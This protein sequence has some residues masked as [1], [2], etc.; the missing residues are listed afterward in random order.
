MGIPSFDGHV[1]TRQIQ[2]FA[3]LSGSRRAFFGQCIICVRIPT[4]V[5]QLQTILP[6]GN[7]PLVKPPHKNFP[8]DPTKLTGLHRPVARLNLKKGG[9]ASWRGD[10]RD[11]VGGEILHQ[12]R[13]TLWT[14]TMKHWDPK[15]WIR[16]GSLPS[17]NRCRIS[18]PSR[19]LLSTVLQ[20]LW[21]QTGYMRLI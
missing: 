18:Q 16:R 15:N 6:D 7:S 14:V 21:G 3:G 12:L 20:F 19:C 9:T 1:G 8:N 11:P 13:V 4:I 2:G 17:T 5:L 10:L